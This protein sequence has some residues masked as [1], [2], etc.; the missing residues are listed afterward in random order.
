MTYRVPPRLN[1]LKKCM[2]WFPV[3]YNDPKSDPAPARP[4]DGSAAPQGSA[5]GTPHFAAPSPF[6]P[7]AVLGG[8]WP[9]I[10]RGISENRVAV[11]SVLICLFVFVI[12]SRAKNSKRKL[13][14][15]PRSIPIIGNLSQIND[16]KWLFSREC[17]EQFG[18]QRELVQVG[19][20]L[21]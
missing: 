15:Q 11:I 9:S 10:T 13:P 3:R 14:P 17:K 18:E 20:I 6:N 16:K 1:A 5:S 19:R 2:G 8:L 7:F 4:L 12:V 21:T